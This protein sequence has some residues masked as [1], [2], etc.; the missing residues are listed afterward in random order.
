M[1][2][3]KQTGV[4]YYMNGRTKQ[5]MPL[6]YQL[7]E[8]YMANSER[9]NIEKAIKGL[10]IPVLLC[11]GSQDPAVPVQ[12]ARDLHSWQPASELFIVD[13]D[14]VFGRKHPWTATYLPEPMQLVVHKTI[15]F[16]KEANKS[17]ELSFFI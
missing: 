11:H 5:Q 2:E 6:Y 17:L 10:K 7:Y 16:F 1:E 12:K 14:H 4:A 8:D 3:W 13:S 9:L 15:Q